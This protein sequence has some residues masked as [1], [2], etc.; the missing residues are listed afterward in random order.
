MDF[1]DT[2][3]F[4]HSYRVL[5]FPAI[6]LVYNLQHALQTFHWYSLDKILFCFAGHKIESLQECSMYLLHQH[7]W[8]N[9]A[10]Q[11]ILLHATERQD[12]KFHQEKFPLS[13]S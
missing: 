8:C 7:V 5:E 10:F 4:F 6:V 12:C 11:R 1:L 2:W 9:E 13:M 3:A